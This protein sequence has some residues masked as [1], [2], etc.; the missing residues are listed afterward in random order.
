MIRRSGAASAS[1]GFG[2]STGSTSSAAR[3]G[4]ARGCFDHAT[5]KALRVPPPLL[6]RDDRAVSGDAAGDDRSRRDP[7]RPEVRRTLLPGSRRVQAG[8]RG[9]GIGS[10]RA[11]G[12]RGGCVAG[13]ACLMLTVLASTGD[14]PPEKKKMARLKRHPFPDYMTVDRDRGG[15]I[16]RNPITGKKKRFGPHEEAL[17]RQT[18]ER[19]AAWVRK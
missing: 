6:H 17:A 5:G 19:L 15:F 12:A 7:G 3:P 16:V 2:D 9:A 10:G 11:P 8:C 14:R 1:P 4:R 18:A 13:G